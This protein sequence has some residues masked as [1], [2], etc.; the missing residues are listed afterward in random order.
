MVADHVHPQSPI[1]HSGHGRLGLWE[2]KYQ[3]AHTDSGLTLVDMPPGIP[4]RNPIC[5]PVTAG[6]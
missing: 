1:A 3:A 6:F 4:S 2:S 5:D